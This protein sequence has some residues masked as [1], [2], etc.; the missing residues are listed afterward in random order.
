M[1]DSSLKF[2]QEL[3]LKYDKYCAKFFSCFCKRTV[4]IWVMATLHLFY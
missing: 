1:I 2:K 3:L 4:F